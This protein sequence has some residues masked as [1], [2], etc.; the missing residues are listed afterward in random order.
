MRE[1]KT[2]AKRIRLDYY[3]RV[4]WLRRGVLLAS[5]ASAIG[6]CA[7]LIS[8]G[9]SVVV[10]SEVCVQH[11]SIRLGD[12]NCAACHHDAPPPLQFANAFRFF[13]SPPNSA[14]NS[15]K[16]CH[17][18]G[19]HPIP[20]IGSTAQAKNVY[21]NCSNCHEEHLGANNM[22][23]EV[24]DA[25]CAQCHDGSGD[26]CETRTAP[27]TAFG[28]SHP[29]FKLPKTDP[30]EIKFNHKLHMELGSS[31]AKRTSTRVEM[32]KDAR[33]AESATEAG[34]V[35]MACADCHGRIGV[36][37]QSTIAP[38]DRE[39]GRRMT[40]I[41]YEQHCAE[42][43]SIGGAVLGAAP[44]LHAIGWPQMRETIRS[45]VVQKWDGAAVDLVVE[46]R[47]AIAKND[48]LKCHNNHVIDETSTTKPTPPPARWLV[49]GTFDHAAHAAVACRNCH[50]K[51]SEAVSSLTVDIPAKETCVRCHLPVGTPVIAPDTWASDRCITCHK[52]HDHTVSN[53]PPKV[54][55]EEK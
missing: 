16:K 41:N 19:G 51:S 44:L 27:A 35:K 39:I 32:L 14:T 21:A 42:C 25:R 8:A 37:G 22:L 6:L 34:L 40:P 20:T 30:G 9:G 1:T 54:L 26:V 23:V 49:A 10:P 3:K 17:V 38:D 15:C 13:D 18:V 45:V 33:F 53:E 2:R 43:H 28:S 46:S 4:D 11:Q 47:V 29:A 5:L 48:C 7:Y 24:D 36:S 52:F 31:K 12:D 55:E 50:E